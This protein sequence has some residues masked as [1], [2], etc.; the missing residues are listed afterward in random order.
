MLNIFQPLSSSPVMGT[1]HEQPPSLQEGGIRN[2]WFHLGVLA[3]VLSGIHAASHRCP[4]GTLSVWASWS[5]YASFS[6]MLALASPV[7]AQGS[8]WGILG[9]L[10]VSMDSSWWTAQ[11]HFLFLFVFLASPCRSF[12]WELSTS[13]HTSGIFFFLLG[14]TLLSGYLCNLGYYSIGTI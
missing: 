9:D 2:D 5:A 11:L 7:Y 14:K 8:R 4:L 12:P 1:L 6:T 13:T 3:P 10:F